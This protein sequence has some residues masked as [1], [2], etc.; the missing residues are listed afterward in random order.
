MTDKIEG[1]S[2]VR[3]HLAEIR[4]K[5][6]A[7]LTAQ[8]LR[9]IGYVTRMVVYL[10]PLVFLAGFLWSYQSVLNQS[11]ESLTAIDFLLVGGCVLG[12]LGIAIPAILFL[13]NVD[14]DE[15][16]WEA[17]GVVGLGLAA[18]ALAVSLSLTYGVALR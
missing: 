13:F 7:K 4:R 12:F 1:P 17:W 18:A 2:K 10:G 6:Q 9:G 11:L 15:I 8:L 5:R 16:D 14:G 3:R